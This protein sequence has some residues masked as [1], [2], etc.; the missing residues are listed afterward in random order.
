MRLSTKEQY[1]LRM[2]VEL[3]RYH[4]QGPVALSQV[5]QTQQ[6]PLPYL[7]Q[8]VIPLRHAGLLS[9]ARGAHGGYALARTP[10][11]I[12]VGD[13]VRALEGAILPIPCI[14]EESGARCERKGICAVSNVWEVIHARL[15]DTLDAM[16]LSGLLAA[17]AQP[18][19][20]QE[21]A[22]CRSHRSAD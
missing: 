11:Q 9:S 13:V 22:T 10:D 8:I 2:M 16:T 1:G 19:A 7:E 17:A 4:G 15:V 12:S 6:L 20:G 14:E 3:A 5:A 18:A 21:P